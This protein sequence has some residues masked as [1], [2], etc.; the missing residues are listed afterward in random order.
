MIDTQNMKGSRAQTSLSLVI[1]S[2]G[3]SI[4]MEK[5]GHTVETLPSFLFYFSKTVLFFFLV[6]FFE[7][8]SDDVWPLFQ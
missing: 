7:I 2:K 5:N 8:L 3:C 1:E 4:F 6:L